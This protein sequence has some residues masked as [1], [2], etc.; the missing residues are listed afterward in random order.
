M[1]TKNKFGSLLL[2]AL[3][4]L[5]VL[6]GCVTTPSGKH[7]MDAEKISKLAPAL[8]ATVS[9]AVIYAYTK[10]TN[11]VVYVALVRTVVQE[12]A[13]SSDLSAA[14]LRARINA[15]P[16]KQLKTAEAQLVITP[17]ISAYKAY[18]EQ[19]VQAGIAENEG[20]KI[21]LRAV[22]EGIA[23]GEAGIAQIAK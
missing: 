16:V 1:K 9:G 13:L 19:Y 10:D 21:L 14:N 12:F 20:L 17:I 6:T 22:S 11:A 23:D 15:L 7:V 18:G 8:Q 5:C 3:F 2:V 4:A